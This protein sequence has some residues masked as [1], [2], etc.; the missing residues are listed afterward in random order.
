MSLFVLFWLVAPLYGYTF[1]QDFKFG[2]ASASYQI[3]GGWN[4]SGKGE[5]I[6]DRMTHEHPEKIKDGQTGDIACDSYNLWK[7]D[8]ALLKELEV[9]FYRF[10]LSWSRLLPT[11][12]PN[13]INDDGVRYY[14]DLIN[15]LLKNNILPMVTL[16]HWDLPQP[17]QDIGGWENEII[18]YYF[19]K[20]AEIAFELFGDRV[21]TWITINEP[22]EVCDTGYGTGI[23]AP[24]INA[25]GYS[26]YQC[27]RT[28]LLAHAMAYHLYNTSFRNQ[29][30]GE[31]GITLNSQWIEPKTKSV[32]DKKASERAMRMELGWW[33]H[34]IFSKTGDYPPIMKERIHNMSM[35]QHFNKS[36]LP[37]FSL[38]EINYIRSTSDFFG[39]N[40]YSTWLASE[41]LD[42]NCSVVSYE[43][44]KGVDKIQDS[45]WIPSAADWLKDVP[46]GFRKLLNWIRKEYNDPI[47]YITENGFADLG[48]LDDSER[49]HYH[50]GYL[51][52]LLNA[53]YLDGCR[54]ETYT[55]WSLTDNM[56]WADGY[57]L[58]F[59]LYYVNFTDPFRTR[60]AKSSAEFFRE[61]IRHRVVPDDIAE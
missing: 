52:E 61:V 34:P 19:S 38:S 8:V 56:E 3:E 6:W 24:G 13:F 57:T 23:N 43:N 18:A 36:R 14:N 11:G 45:R 32:A 54:V 35:C 9:N 1:P 60:K 28:L 4:A 42:D 5:N 30:Q 15:E 31:I 22:S 40:H 7:T 16:Y 46:W 25:S 48:Q 53:M 51:R 55:A 17:L 21:K 39:L 47:I 26:N 29:Q 2:V 44:D 33:A 20:F 10:S 50:K 41:R 27:G 49:I 12:L 37:E 58:K 59:G